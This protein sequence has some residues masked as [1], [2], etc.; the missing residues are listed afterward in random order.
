MI[1]LTNAPRE[2]LQSG[3]RQTLAICG[4]HCHAG[5]LPYL[6]HQWLT[7]LWSPPGVLTCPVTNSVLYLPGIPPQTMTDPLCP[8]RSVSLIRAS[9]IGSFSRLHTFLGHQLL[10][11]KGGPH[12]SLAPLG[13]VAWHNSFPSIK[14]SN[15]CCSVHILSK[16]EYK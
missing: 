16:Y 7:P 12:Q 9:A 4:H 13:M 15:V 6:I 3:A 10:T 14:C 11:V 8:T 2:Y 1:W 5:T